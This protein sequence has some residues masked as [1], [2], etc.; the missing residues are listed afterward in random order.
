MKVLFF[1]PY[2]DLLFEGN[3]QSKLSFINEIGKLVEIHV[4]YLPHFISYILL[5][6]IIHY[7]PFASSSTKN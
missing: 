7:I 2:A 4:V 1:I 5:H 6:G 3:T